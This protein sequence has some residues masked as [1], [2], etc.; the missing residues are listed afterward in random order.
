MNWKRHLGLIDDCALYFFEAHWLA[1]FVLYPGGFEC[2][3]ALSLTICRPLLDF[4]SFPVPGYD[5]FPFPFHMFILWHICYLLG[6]TQ[7]LTVWWEVW[8]QATVRRGWSGSLSGPPGCV[9]H[10]WSPPGSR[11][12]AHLWETR[13]RIM[14]L[15]KS[16]SRL[17]QTRDLLCCESK[18]TLNFQWSYTQLKSLL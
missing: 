17:D 4:S 11:Q 5:D 13:V 6:A 2:N 10:R 3:S 9:P 7:K 14:A 16:L 1:L 8:R 12:S 15:V 18:A